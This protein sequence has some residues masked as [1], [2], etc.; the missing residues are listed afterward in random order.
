MALALVGAAIAFWIGQDRESAASPS[1][2]GLS[3]AALE[4]KS[5][6]EK[7]C[8]ECHGLDAMGT[9]KGPPLIHRI[10][11][12]GHHSDISFYMAV[13]NGVKAHHWPFGDMP[14]QPEV[15]QDQVAMILR[16]IRES[17]LAAGIG[18]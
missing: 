17:Q 16:Y 9:D 18:S 11:K 15:T 2:P 13:Q 5:V 4:G 14:A 7:N 1:A 10:Y 8:G 3:T 12:P 6:F